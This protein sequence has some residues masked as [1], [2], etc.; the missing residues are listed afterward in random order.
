MS[1]LLQATLYRMRKTMGVKV[2]MGLICI[3]AVLYYVL[4]A[5]LADGKFE[6]AQ[7]GSITGL[8]DAMIL[9]IFGSLIVGTL[10]GTDFEN[11]TI[12]GTIKFGRKKIIINY[13][14][15]FSILV[16][17]MVLPYTIGSVACIVAGVDMTGAEGTVIS[18]Y[19]SNVLEHTQETSI[20]KLI[21]SYVTYAIVYIGQL[22]VCIPVAI[23]IKKT[24]VVTAFGFFFGMITALI[25]TLASKVDLLDNIYRLTPYHYGIDKIGVNANA[26]DMIAAIAVS[27]CFTAVMA[28][29]SR[30]IFR[31]SDIK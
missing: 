1:Q 7:A 11:K 16:L 18:I 12:H 15:V 26:G 31:K 10:V 4:A 30:C 22:S 8:G 27:L 29:V 3:A 24:V 20:G 13:M 9:W 28:L 5:M 17:L 19:M 2:S 25:A 14:L 21:L 23:K 6:A